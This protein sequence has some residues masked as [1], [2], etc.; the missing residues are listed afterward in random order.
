MVAD[1]AV[2]AQAWAAWRAEIAFADEL[3]AATPELGPRARMSDGEEISL[4]ELL[5]HMIEEYA[6][7]TATLT[8][9]VSGSTAGWASSAGNGDRTDDRRNGRR[10]DDRRNAVRAAG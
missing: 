4:R 10:Y 8:C 2:V 1:P 5:V 3:V 9:C 6:R 7:T